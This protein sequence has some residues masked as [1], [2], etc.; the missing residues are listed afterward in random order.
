MD[1]IK[2][3]F[4]EFERICISRWCLLIYRIAINFNFGPGKLQKFNTRWRTL[5]EFRRFELGFFFQNQSSLEF[6]L[7]GCGIML[8]Q[9]R[10][11]S[12]RHE[13]PLCIA[14][15]NQ[16]SALARWRFL[17][18]LSVS[19]GKGFVGS[20]NVDFSAFHVLAKMQYHRDNMRK[21]GHTFFH[22]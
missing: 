11:L 17:R 1:T 2:H 3:D 13:S 14:H 12:L 9:L 21:L 18:F 10:Y 22:R 20:E 16:V 5:L 6:R 19:E 8:L 7:R 15:L 4:T